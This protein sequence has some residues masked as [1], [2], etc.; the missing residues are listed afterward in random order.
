MNSE[1]KWQMTNAK[2]QHARYYFI[3]IFHNFNLSTFYFSIPCFANDNFHLNTC[4]SFGIAM[5]TLLFKALDQHFFHDMTWNTWIKEEKKYISFF[6]FYVFD[7]H[8][9]ESLQL[10]IVSNANS[11]WHLEF[12]KALGRIQWFLGICRFKIFVFFSLY[13]I[14]I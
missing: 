2:G 14:K 10:G 8:S 7:L 6:P 11:I 5:E 3:R 13:Y 12:R 4:L 1:N 9:E